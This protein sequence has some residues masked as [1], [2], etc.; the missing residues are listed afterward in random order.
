MKFLGLFLL[1]GAVAAQVELDFTTCCDSGCIADLRS[2]T[3]DP[4][5]LS[6]DTFPNNVTIVLVGDLRQAVV[7]GSY[8]VRATVLGIPVVTDDGSICDLADCP[9]PAGTV[10]IKYVAPILT[11][12]PFG[13]PV[14]IHV[15]AVDPSAGL[16][17]CVDFSFNVGC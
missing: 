2:I 3:A 15:E 9:L 7:D 10:P 12:P 4:D 11:C 14:I 13:S 8:T 16:V 5:P 1:V 17:T 6:I